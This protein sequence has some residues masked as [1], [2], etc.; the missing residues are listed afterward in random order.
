M[1]FPG[2]VVLLL[3][4]CVGT[5]LAEMLESQVVE[6][7][8]GKPLVNAA[9]AAVWLKPAKTPG[10]RPEIL[11]IRELETDSEGRFKVER[12]AGFSP[13]AELITVYKRGYTAWS[14]LGSLE[15]S[16][17]PASTTVPDTTVPAQIELQLFPAQGRHARH[18]YFLHWVTGAVDF[19]WD[20]L[21]KFRIAIE[22][23][24]Q[25]AAR[26]PKP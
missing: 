5:S 6:A 15:D 11:A 19:G 7:Q 10:S 1:R 17:P 13:G 24:W 8:T 4:F 2:L 20:L 3:L 9:V 16:G 23:E 14:N 21:P 22:Q 26:E 18:L 25:G 12:P